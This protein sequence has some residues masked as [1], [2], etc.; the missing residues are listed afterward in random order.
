MA[1]PPATIS[2]RGSGVARRVPDKAMLHMGV[3]ATSSTASE[4]LGKASA[5]ADRLMAALPALDLS[6]DDVAT[7]G[8]NV[9]PQQKPGGPGSGEF[10]ASTN[11]VIGVQDPARVGEVLDSMF[12][13]IG[14][15]LRLHNVS[16]VLS[17]TAE[18]EKAARGEAVRNA[19]GVA[20][21]LA[22]AA[23][24]HLGALLSMGEGGIGPMG[25]PRVM[26]ASGAP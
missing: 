16:L 24:G 17:D 1:Q 22:T 14:D 10:V 2:V 15:G 20:E 21:Q 11:L 9:R 18:L 13:A 19:R 25:M 4:A 26:P 8:V 3:E 5:D 23:G 7:T 6:D 12:E